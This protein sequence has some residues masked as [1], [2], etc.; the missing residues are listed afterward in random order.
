MSSLV[1][2]VRQV[3]CQVPGCTTG[4]INPLGVHVPGPYLTDP[5]CSSV[6]ERAADLAQHVECAHNFARK[7][8]ETEATVKSAEAKKVEA[9]AKKIAAEADKLRAESEAARAGTSTS[10]VSSRSEDQKKGE[11]KAPM[12]RPTVEDNITESDW[13]FFRAEWDRYATAT[14]LGDDSAAAV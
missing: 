13:S 14:E 1:K 5:D 6:A 9:D 11:R 12:P 2:M 3:N 7:E 4:G 10:G 8:R